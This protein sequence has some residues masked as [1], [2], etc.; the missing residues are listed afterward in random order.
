MAAGLPEVP[1]RFGE[2]LEFDERYE[3]QDHHIVAAFAE[4]EVPYLSVS[5]LASQ[6][7][8]SPQ[9]TRDRLAR[10]EELGVLDSRPG[11][12]GRI[13]W[14]HDDRSDWPIPPDVEVVPVETEPTISDLLA[15]MDVKIGLLAALSGYLTTVLFVVGLGLE[16]FP[17]TTRSVS[18][19]VLFGAMLTAGLSLLVGVAA[20]GALLFRLWSR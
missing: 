20:V 13:Y 11:A 15:R 9:G 3:V 14:L 12:N 5:Q 19:P 4:A 18:A 8:M 1:D 16:L 6:L 2:R 17:G 10:L 7:D